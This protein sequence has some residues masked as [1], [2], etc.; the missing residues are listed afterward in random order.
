MNLGIAP[1]SEGKNPFTIICYLCGREYGT[2]SIDIHEKQCIEKWE[3]TNKALPKEQRKPRP[4]KP[5]AIDNSTENPTSNHKPVGSQSMQ[6]YNDAAFA[7]YS[8]NARYECET[9][10]RKVAFID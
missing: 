2:K 6:D 8:E 4:Q 9:C 10:G 1:K 7:A 3:K 5:I